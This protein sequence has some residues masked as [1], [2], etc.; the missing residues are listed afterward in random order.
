MR[1]HR[2]L[3]KTRYTQFKKESQMHGY[4][5]VIVWTVPLLLIVAL[6][7]FLNNNKKEPLSAKEILDMRFAKGEIDEEEYKRKRDALEKQ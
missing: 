7:Y 6:V 4:E 1:T 2:F 5:M 3:T